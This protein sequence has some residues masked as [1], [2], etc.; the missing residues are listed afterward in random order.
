MKQ[1]SFKPKPCECGSKWHSSWQCPLKR[2]TVMRRSKR[3]IRGESVKTKSRRMKTRYEWLAANP[4]DEDGYWY[5][6]ISKHPLC[7]RKLTIESLN[8]EHNLSKTRRPDLR[9]DIT[10]I[11]PACRWD[12][13]AKGSLSAKEY[14][15]KE[16]K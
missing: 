4:P 12:N 10:N 2:K 1:S 15:D 5:C 13:Q 14:M 7:P 6:Y 3:A 16:I 8:L 9:D 11:F